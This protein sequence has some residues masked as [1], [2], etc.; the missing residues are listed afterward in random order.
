MRGPGDLRSA[1]SVSS[2]TAG[3]LLNLNYRSLVWKVYI[4]C[5]NTAG[6]AMGLDN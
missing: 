3:V 4:K 2:S 5:F 6:E 1:A